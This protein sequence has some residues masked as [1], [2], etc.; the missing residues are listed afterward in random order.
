MG[1]IN[2]A[3][4][5]VYYDECP[6]CG[7]PAGYDGFHE[8]TIKKR[9]AQKAKVGVAAALGMAVGIIGEC[10]VQNMAEKILICERCGFAVKT[11]GWHRVREKGGWRR[12]KSDI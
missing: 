2:V 9:G 1:G 4:S 5:Y 6:R 10:T 12:V 7:A 8:V 3:R 11:N